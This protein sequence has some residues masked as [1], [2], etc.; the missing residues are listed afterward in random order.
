MLSIECKIEDAK[1]LQINI[2]SAGGRL[3]FTESNVNFKG[4]YKQ[5]LD[6]S[7]FPKGI[8]FI[9]LISDKQ[10]MNKKIVLN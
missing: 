1:S 4:V 8:Y 6:L 7:A 10:V 3:I 5:N 9:Q 2:M